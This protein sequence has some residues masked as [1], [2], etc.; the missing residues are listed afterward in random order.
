MHF[1]RPGPGNVSQRTAIDAFAVTF[2]DFRLDRGFR[3]E[4]HDPRKDILAAACRR[5]LDKRI[6]PDLHLVFRMPLTA[7]PAK[8]GIARHAK[9]RTERLGAQA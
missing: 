7:L 4:L 5:F 9:A 2:A 6:K 3:H 8:D 1:E